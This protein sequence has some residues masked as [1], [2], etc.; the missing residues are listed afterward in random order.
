MRV[1]STTVHEEGMRNKPAKLFA[2]DVVEK[3]NRSPGQL[4]ATC[5]GPGAYGCPGTRPTKFIGG[6]TQSA[7]SY[8]R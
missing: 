1:F 7:A 8:P 5:K 2:G 6:S 3:P 4:G